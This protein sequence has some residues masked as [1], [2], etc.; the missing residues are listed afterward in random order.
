MTSAGEPEE[1]TSTTRGERVDRYQE[2]T[3]ILWDERL[4]QLLTPGGFDRLF[5]GP[6]PSGRPSAAEDDPVEARVRRALER[7]GPAFIKAGQLLAT[8]RDLIS[9][10]LVA[11]LEK[12]QDNVPSVPYEDIAARIEEE[13]GAPPAEIYATFDE[14]PLAAASIG[15][16]HRATLKDGRKVV[17]KVQRPGVTEQMAIDLDIM[18]RQSQSAGKRLSFARDLDVPGVA[19]RFLD[20]LRS[21]LDY[22]R[23]ARNME[24]FRE[25]FDE[26]D[27]VHIPWVEW[28]LTTSRVLTMEELDG[29]PGTRLEEMDAAGV[30]R[31][32]LVEKGVSAYLKMIFIIGAFHSDPH[33]GNLFAMSDGA[34]GFL[35]FGRVSAIGE[36]D[37]DRAMDLVSALVDAD[38]VRATEVLIETTRAGPDVDRAALQHD[39]AEL[40]DAYL[41]TGAR[42]IGLDGVFE[43]MFGMV[44]KYGLQMPDE[45]AMLFITMGTLEGV[46]NT[47]DPSFSFAEAAQPLVEKL[48][49]ERWGQERLQRALRRSGPRYFRLAED[50]PFLLDGALRRASSGEFR[51]AVRPVDTEEL[52]GELE[53]IASRLS[54]ALILAALILGTAMLLSRSDT[55]P[56][57]LLLIFD[58]VAIVAIATV[59]W[60]L[61]SAFRR[62]RG[63][64]R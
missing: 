28:D 1:R 21:E 13:L 47:L 25:A 23:E 43:R 45:L 12:L 6:K 64:R 37:R 14:E 50:L 34:V 60:L 61:I 36:R 58:V 63:K 8:R 46:A 44:R 33:Q 7:L 42:S 35:D 4:Y 19:A 18:E 41:A 17:V 26:E 9:P 30:D 15:Q 24:M 32:A 22:L 2:I 10:A 62:S 3:A 39:V 20:A 54:F 59:T 49:P 5:V 53:S 11:E 48:L 31:K 38:E 56:D 51:L 55:I 40:I 52:T 29:I 27:E 57:E 16:V